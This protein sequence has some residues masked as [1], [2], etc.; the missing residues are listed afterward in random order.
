MKQST[1]IKGSEKSASKVVF[2]SWSFAFYT[3]LTYAT[4]LS[5]NSYHEFSLFHWVIFP[6]DPGM[7]TA[8]H[9][10]APLQE[11]SSIQSVSD[12]SPFEQLPKELLAQIVG[13][14]PEAEFEMR[15]VSDIFRVFQCFNQSILLF[16]CRLVAYWN[17]S[18]TSTSVVRPSFRSCKESKYQ[19]VRLP[20][21]FVFCLD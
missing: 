7:E 9:L 17:L 10:A 18:W 5:H 16:F 12:L 14:V 20:A 21:F 13:H 8:A 2:I 3:L 1:Y 4:H 19:W 15:L 11:P 6:Q